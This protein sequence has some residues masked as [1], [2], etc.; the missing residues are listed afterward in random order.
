MMGWGTQ[1][2][3]ANLDGNLDLLVANGHLE[4]RGKD[5]QSTMPTQYFQNVGGGRFVQGPAA[6]LG[7]YFGQSWFGRAVARADWNRDGLPDALVTHT[8]SPVALLTNTT[9]QH[10]DSVRLICVGSDASSRD[11]LGATLRLRLGDRTLMR[12]VTGGDGFMASNQKLVIF[13]VLP[14]ETLQSLVVEWPSGVTQ[15]IT[16]IPRN[17]DLILQEGSDRLLVLPH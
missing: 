13:G 11:A 16:E 14:D 6:G 1:F 15:T 9:A 12:Q 8:Y 2:L 7:A 3:D 4:D 5:V 17:Q 10:G